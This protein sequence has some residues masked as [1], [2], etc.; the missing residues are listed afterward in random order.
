MIKR[1]NCFSEDLYQHAL[2]EGVEQTKDGILHFPTGKFTGRSPKDRYF[3]EGEYVKRVVDTSREINQIVSRKTYQ[4]LRTMVEDH[5]QNAPVFYRT[6]RALCHN[7]KYVSLFELNTTYA[8]ANLFFNNMTN[9][10]VE[11]SRKPNEFYTNWK[12]LHAPDFVAPPYEDIKNGNFVIID[13]EDKTILIG[14]TSYTGEIKKSIFTVLNT[15]LIDEGV[16][17]MHCSAN[18]NTKKGKG[19]NLFFGLSGTGK[20]TLSSDPDKFF[21]GDDEHGWVDDEVFNFEGG[22]YAKLINLKEENEP[23][24]WEALHSESRYTNVNTT[25]MENI[26]VNKEGTPDFSDASITE[27]IRASYPLD[28]IPEEYMV[29]DIG[30]GKKV[31]NIFFLSFDA[32]GVLPPISKLEVEDAARFFKMGYTSKVAGTEVGIIEPTVVFSTCF[33]SPFLPR[34]VD[35]YVDLFK[36]KVKESGCNVWLVNTGFNENLKRYPI[37]ITRKVINGVINGKYS[38][39]TF[40]F[41]GL[42]IPN[43]IE[44]LDLLTLKPDVEQERVDKLFELFQEQ[45]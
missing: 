26:F 20:T 12:I 34:K 40:D 13:F 38:K 29:E 8:W 11:Y 32:F 42:K 31:E 24:I 35:D 19:V 1:Y 15:I 14:G 37:D 10:S 4:S 33:G 25:L 9:N 28:Q 45:N 27:N 44:D 36:K 41:N 17:P 3:C 23:I 30:K 16:L 21:I 2:S 18:A 6:S 39:Q 22:C 43:R 5:L 7:E